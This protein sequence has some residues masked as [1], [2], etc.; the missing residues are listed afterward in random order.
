MIVP[1]VAHEL[2]IEQ[3]IEALNKKL[4]TEFTGIQPA[5]PPVP[6][7]LVAKLTAEVRSNELKGTI[8][9]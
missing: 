9:H 4:F 8:G 5:M 7:V 2:S 1:D 6:R 3:L